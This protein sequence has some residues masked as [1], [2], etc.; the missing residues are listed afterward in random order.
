MSAKM[1]Q[2]LIIEVETGRAGGN[3]D[4]GDATGSQDPVNLVQCREIIIDVLEHVERRDA[5]NAS[6]W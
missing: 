2:H 6:V 1:H 4:V 5:V 3:L